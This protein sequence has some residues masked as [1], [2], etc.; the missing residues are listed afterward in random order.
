MHIFIVGSKGK[1]DESCTRELDEFF[2]SELFKVFSEPIRWE[3]VKFLA[4]HGSSD[5]ST[6]AGSFSQDRSVIS[7]HLSMMHRAGILVRVDKSRFKFYDVNGL[8][9]YQN[10]EQITEKLGKLLRI[11][12]K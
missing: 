6:I 9:L 11:N 5:I 1:H 3:I 2:S 12:V 7:R 10:F 4:Y 8:K